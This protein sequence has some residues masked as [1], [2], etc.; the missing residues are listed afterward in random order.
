MEFT[1]DVLENPRS[2]AAERGDRIYVIG[3]VHG[4]LDLLR[5]LLDRIGEHAKAQGPVS[6]THIVLLGDLIDRGDQSAEVLKLVYN[7]AQRNDSL[8]TLMG[9]HEEL[10]LR[11]YDGESSV[12]RV[13][14]RT[15]G[16]ETLR[17]FGLV[18][19]SRDSDPRAFLAQMKKAIPRAIID[20]MRTLPLTVRSGDYLFCHAGIRP[21][22]ALRKQAK[23]DL[24]WIRDEFLNDTS[25]HGAV[26]VHG[27]SISPEPEVCV[28]RIGLDT[29]AYKTGILTALYLEGTR[30]ELLAVRGSARYA[31]PVEEEEFAGVGAGSGSSA[32][33]AGLMRSAARL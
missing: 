23:A 18:P 19:P 31:S 27:H 6:S 2:T 7:I 28:N 5:A 9:N 17:S 24:L 22:V 14:M 32:G 4:R 25:A 26:I 13:W 16:A 30:R 29:G 10:M 21:G 11:A 8:I 12:L 1:V 15:G 33:S 20:W 3:D